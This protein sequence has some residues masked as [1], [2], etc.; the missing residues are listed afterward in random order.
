[1][2]EPHKLVSVITPTYNAASTLPQCVESVRNQTYANWEHIIVDDGSTD[3]TMD[4]LLELAK[5][6]ERIR[7][8]R[9][10]NRGQAAARNVAISVSKGA[11]IA[12]LDSDDHTV[13]HRLQMQVEFLEKNRDVHVLGGAIYSTS[14]SG[15]QLGI[16][17][18]PQTQK[19]LLKSKYRATPF[20]TSTVMARASFFR[21]LGGF[22]TNLRRCEDYDL[23]LRGFDGF[24][25]HNMQ[26]P[27]TYY[28]T[29]EPTW[30]DAKY[31]AYVRM[32]QIRRD[33]KPFSYAWYAIRPLLA[34]LLSRMK[35]VSYSGMVET[36]S[37]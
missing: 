25:Y 31:S 12:L 3:E 6:D 28:R 24:K 1:M 13:S 10:C 32:R 16:N 22:D 23:W 7:L 11:Y 26:I 9:Q 34:F 14:T 35:L 27:L 37:L 18:L 4:L 15:T 17:R 21:I 8:I 33:Q 36:R 2:R 20:Y 30:R 5:H 29:S 19:E